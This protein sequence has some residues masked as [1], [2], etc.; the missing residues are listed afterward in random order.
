MASKTRRSGDHKTAESVDRKTRKPG[1]ETSGW[2]KLGIYLSP[3]VARRLTLQSIKRGL[4]RSTIVN[5]LL[6]SHLPD[7]IITDRV[8]STVS[9]PDDAE[10][11]SSESAAA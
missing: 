9:V 8:A 5:K 2:D 10:L 11:S 1:K 4:D 3:D 6:D 7:L